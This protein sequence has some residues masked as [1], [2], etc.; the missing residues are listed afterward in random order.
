M[1]K[2]VGN[3]PKQRLHKQFQQCK[4]WELD[5][6]MNTY[7]KEVSILVKSR[8]DILHIQAELHIGRQVRTIDRKCPF[9]RN[10]AE[11]EI[12][13]FFIVG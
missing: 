11:H 12:H 4:N 1:G 3:R 9:C 7:R 2:T 5:I 10:A 6:G 13:F 8:L